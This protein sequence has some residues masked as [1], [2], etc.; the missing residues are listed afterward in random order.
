M[1][2][3]FYISCF[4]AMII[5][6][7]YILYKFYTFRTKKAICLTKNIASNQVMMILCTLTTSPC[8]KNNV[9]E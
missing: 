6:I 8:H 3:K 2:E 9:T 5:S 4:V 7:L 1:R